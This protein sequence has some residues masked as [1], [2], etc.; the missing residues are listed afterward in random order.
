MTLLS[1]IVVNLTATGTAAVLIALIGAI[2]LLGLFGHG[3]LA[4]TALGAL[5]LAMGILVLALAQRA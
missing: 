3:A 2:T 5:V 4:N 1:N